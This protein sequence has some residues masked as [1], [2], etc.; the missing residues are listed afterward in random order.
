MRKSTDI[1]VQPGSVL[2]SYSPQESEQLAVRW[3]TSFGGN[4][5]PN[6]KSYMWHALSSRAYPSLSLQEAIARYELEVAPSFVVLSND[7]DQAVE[8]DQ[9]PTSCSESDFLVFPPNMA[10]TMAFTHEDGWLGPYFAKHSQYDKLN[11]E[12]VKKIEKARAIE[13]AKQRGWL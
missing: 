3:L 4:G 8:T 7:R 13:Q 11:Q 2:R 6:T 12:N 9:R 1:E 10:W 5:A